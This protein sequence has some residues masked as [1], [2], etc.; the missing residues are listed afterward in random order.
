MKA[1]VNAISYY[2][3]K[4]LTNQDIS[5]EFPEW[6]I[7]KISNKVGINTTY[8]RQKRN[9]RRYGFKAAEKLFEEY[10]IEQDDYLILCTQS[11]GISAYYCMHS[12]RQTGIVRR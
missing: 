1:I 6:S 8:C 7:T 9:C 10:N 5:E 11:P 4:I 12:A 3:P 2:L